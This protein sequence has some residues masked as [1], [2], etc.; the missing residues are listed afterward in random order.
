MNTYEC[1]ICLNINHN[2]HFHCS[3]CGTIPAKYSVL[4]VPARF[5]PIVADEPIRMIGVV[6]ARGADRAEHHHTTRTYMRT[7][8]A[9][10]YAE[11]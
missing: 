1:A 7:V 4:N 11:A 8:P 6:V 3:T 5:V 10:Y 9:D 2:S